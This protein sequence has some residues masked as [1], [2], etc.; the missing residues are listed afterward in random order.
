MGA[1]TAIWLSTLLML[2]IVGGL[3]C[4]S[5]EIKTISLILPAFMLMTI[6]YCATLRTSILKSANI[7][8]A[9]C[10]VYACLAS[11]TRAIDSIVYPK[12]IEPWFGLTGGIVFN[13]FLLDICNACVL[14]C[15]SRSVRPNRRRKHCSHMVCVLDITHCFYR[16]KHIYNT[17]ESK[18]SAYRKNYAGIYC[19]LLYDARFA[20]AFLRFVL[21]NGKK[22]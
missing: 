9:V 11:I 20:F 13:I 21:H 2:C 10:G 6:A 3:F 22:P 17:V 14:P 5:F 1:L 16:H 12:N 7:A 19:N 4:Y 15:L 18:H 8:L